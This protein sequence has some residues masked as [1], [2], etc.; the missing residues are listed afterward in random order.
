MTNHELLEIIYDLEERIEV[1][2][3]VAY[4]RVGAYVYA[5]PIDIE[6]FMFTPSDT[7]NCPE[8]KFRYVGY[9]D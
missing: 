2:E 3:E 5:Y 6:D 1:L 9:G 8:I 4:E 7:V